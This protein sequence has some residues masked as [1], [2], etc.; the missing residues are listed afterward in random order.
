M[1]KASQH[2][3]RDT[4]LAL[5][6][7]I[8]YPAGRRGRIENLSPTSHCHVHGCSDTED[9]IAC[10]WEFM[11]ASP[12]LLVKARRELKGYELVCSCGADENCHADIL[13]AIANA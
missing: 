1:A 13:P 9:A 6:K 3:R 5:G 4:Q 10:Y 8:H 7:S 2:R 12:D 11:K